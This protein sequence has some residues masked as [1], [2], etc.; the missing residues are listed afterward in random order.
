[1]VSCCHVLCCLPKNDHQAS[2]SYVLICYC[3]NSLDILIVPFSCSLSECKRKLTLCTF[4]YCS[5][6]I[7]PFWTLYTDMFAFFLMWFLHNPISIVCPADFSLVHERCV[8]RS[9]RR[10]SVLF[11]QF[12]ISTRRKVK[13]PHMK[14]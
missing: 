11:H 10:P 8:G 6:Q 13:L 14:I 4:V 12:G 9:N 1:M 3:T 5:I 7:T 2:I